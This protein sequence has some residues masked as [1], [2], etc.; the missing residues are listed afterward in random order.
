MR[1]VGLMERPDHVCCRYRLRAYVPEL[2]SRGWRVELR[3]LM[4]SLLERLYTLRDDQTADV[5]LMQRKLLDGFRLR[6]L[7]YNA[8][9]L[10]FDFDDAVLYRDSYA[11]KGPLCPRRAGRFRRIVQMSDAV[12]TGNSFLAEQAEQFA[13][14]NR[15]HVVPTCVNPARYPVLARHAGS[16]TVQLVWIGSSS[17]LRGLVRATPLFE[18]IGRYVPGTQLKVICDSFPA[19]ERLPVVPVRWS[20]STEAHDLARADIGVSWLPDDLWSRGKCG[21]KILQYM[22]AGLPVVTNAVGVHTEM[23][24]HGRSGF[25]VETKSDW[26]EAISALAADPELRKSMGRHGRRIVDERYSILRWATVLDQIMRGGLEQARAQA[27]L[28][29]HSPILEPALAA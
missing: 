27:P 14:A 21:L 4:S 13:K 24:E 28:I 3:P 29:R 26:I 8:R 9:N 11:S 23:V 16:E 18:A 1:A 20:E 17:T 12:I 25:L 5:V 6:L 19:F 2:E 22:A 7:R 10:V 15:I